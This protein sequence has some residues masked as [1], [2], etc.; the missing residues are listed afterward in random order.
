MTTWFKRFPSPIVLPD[1]RRLHTLQDAA[2]YLTALPKGESEISDWRLAM[3]A[4]TLATEHVGYEKLAQ[5]AVL[6]A[7]QSPRAPEPPKTPKLRVVQGINL[8]RQA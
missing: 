1:G 3:E 2:D 8:N 4:L 7:L 6:H 5:A